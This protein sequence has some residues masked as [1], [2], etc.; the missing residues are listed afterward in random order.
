MIN[1]IHLPAGN[2]VVTL[3]GDQNITFH[4]ASDCSVTKRLIGYN[5]E[6]IDAVFLSPS[7]SSQLAIATNSSQIRMYSTSTAD[8]DTS[9][10]DSHTDMVL[11]LDRNHP[12]TLLASGSKDK[13]ARIWAPS[14]TSSTTWESIAICEGHTESV[15]AIAFSRRPTTTSAPLFLF[16][17]SQDRTV[18]M[19]DISTLSSPTS[20]STPTRPKSILTQIAH[21]KDINSLDVS[22]NDKL[23]ATGSQDK[24]AKI[25]EIVV[26]GNKGSGMRA[27]LKLLGTLKGHKRGVWNVRFSRT[28]RVVAT[29]SADKSVKLWSLETLACVKVRLR[30]FCSLYAMG[31]ADYPDVRRSK[32][33]PTPS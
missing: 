13:S 11:C 33:I 31:K 14:P 26:V 18:K 20:T 28:D 30:V 7:S 6:I 4:S 10:L 15:G 23:L 3:Q 16:T 29:A 5:D 21:D 25:F 8:L 24:T 22:P 1:A 32:V 17:G 19:W 2:M 12:G 27:E 9:L